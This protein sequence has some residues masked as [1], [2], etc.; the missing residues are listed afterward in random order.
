MACALPYGFHRRES[1]Y[2]LSLLVGRKAREKRRVNGGFAV[3]LDH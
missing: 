1:G 2:L 3:H